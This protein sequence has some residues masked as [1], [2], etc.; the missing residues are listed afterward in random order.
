MK[1]KKTKKHKTHSRKGSGK[2]SGKGNYKRDLRREI[3][4][5]LEKVPGKAINYKQISSTLGISDSGVRRLIQEILRDE[6]KKGRLKEVERGKYVAT[7]VKQ[8]NVEGRIE[9]TRG[10]RGFIIVEGHDQD[11]EVSNRNLGKALW[12]DIVEAKVLKGGR[13]K[14]AKVSRVIKRNK[15]QY[16]G[17]IEKSKD[18]AFF[19]PTDQRIHIDFFIPLE[20]LGG[21]KHGEKVI[22][23]IEDWEDVEEKPVAN[24]VKVLGKP[25]ENDVEMHAILAEFGLP[26]DFPDEVRHDAESIPK[27]ITQEEISKRR[28]FRK[29]L[30]FTIDPEDAKD[31]D[32]ALSYQKLEN[33]NIEVGIHIADVSHYLQPK[34]ILDDEA[35]DRATSVYLVDRVIPMLPEVLSNELCSLRPKEEK[36]CFSAVFELDEKANIKKEWF[37]RTVIYSDRRFTY[38]EAQDVIETGKGDHS[39]AILDLDRLAK[40]MRKERQKKGGLDF[41]T[42]EVKFK[43]DENG[44]P[45][46]VFTKVMKDANR[47]IEDFM[48]LANRR[49]AAFIGNPKKGE[50][51]TFVYRVHDD[52]NDDKLA[53]LKQFVSHFG[54]QMSLPKDGDALHVL[55]AL[56]KQSKG[57]PEEDIIKLMAIRSMAKAEYTTENIGHFGLSFDFYSHFTSPIR[58]YPDV[59]VHRL[60]A[61]YL[62]GGSSADQKTYEKHCNHCSIMEKKAVEAERASIKYKQVEFLQNNIGEEFDGVI[63]GL[64]GW[65]LYVELIE[66]KCEGMVSMSNLMSDYFSFDAE[67]YV[68]RGSKTGFE[69]HMG[70]RVRVRVAKA[71]LQKRQLD[72]EMVED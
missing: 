50:P 16:V 58:R 35:Y 56:L 8:Q 13:K 41:D 2:K 54:Y 62:E 61:H 9:I 44:V 38:E 51:K 23:E 14:S 12:G 34:T 55:K 42:E 4:H 65:G 18:F 47:L 72:F 52:P 7:N 43:L 11:F 10:G 5:I 17:V 48:L 53:T 20:N 37:G 67:E 21:A 70:Q 3:F 36:L 28:D 59:M 69:Y 39:E 26:L 64:T 32:D 25:G 66:S 30:T 15:S 40:L 29:I 6:T 49:V 27:E 46:Y 24:V 19:L 60:L 63:S 1:G 22:V 33:G 68:V 71:D 45:I 31:F 57:S